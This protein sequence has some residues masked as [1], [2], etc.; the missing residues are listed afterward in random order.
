MSVEAQK[1]ESWLSPSGSVAT[2]AEGTTNSANRQPE[3]SEVPEREGRE[4][5]SLPA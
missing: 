3:G 2:E 5:R 4:D 1:V